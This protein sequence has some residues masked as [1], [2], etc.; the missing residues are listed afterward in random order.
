M[1]ASNDLGPGGLFS[2]AEPAAIFTS[3][4]A[5]VYFLWAWRT[6]VTLKTKGR[7]L[8]WDAYCKT[9]NWDGKPVPS[10]IPK[11]NTQAQLY[12][13]TPLQ[14]RLDEL[15][16]KSST[17]LLWIAVGIVLGSATLG[18]AMHLGQRRRRRKSATDTPRDLGENAAVVEK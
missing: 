6:Y 12:H 16:S 15:W 8:Y 9:W 11:W 1:D 5:L 17:P 10:A 3:K 14:A 13:H 18:V 2:L 7:V 4:D